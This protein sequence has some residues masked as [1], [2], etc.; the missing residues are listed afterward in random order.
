MKAIWFYLSFVI[1]IGALLGA[2]LGG[3]YSFVTVL[4]AFVI[5][6]VIDLL[7]QQETKALSSDEI[8]RLNL[9][10]SFRTVPFL[11]GVFMLGTFFILAW[12][13]SMKET[14][15]VSFIGITVSCGIATGGVSIAVAH[16]LIHK[17]TSGE[18]ALGKALLL[19]IAYMH[20]YIDHNA[21]HH[22]LVATREDASS[23]RMGES[24][25]RFFP[26]TLIGSYLSAW[27]IEKKRLRKVKSGALFFQNR[28]IQFL[29]FTIGFALLL[30]IL[31]GPK[32]VLFYG[33]Q[34]VLGFT[35]LEV[36]NY[37][38]HYG[39]ERKLEA[40]GRYE[41]V[42]AC[43]SWEANGRVSN[44]VFFKFQR[45]A[46]H[47]IHPSRCYHVLQPLPESPKL[48][49]G[50]PGMALLAFVSP[51]WHWIMDKRVASLQKSTI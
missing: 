47:H 11:F 30:F 37:V 17:S 4:I 22:T 23:A 7:D 38:E 25:F 15:L 31:F 46:D 28:M 40:N 9:K 10:K 48:P 13:A 26:R 44:Y 5:I 42:Q 2:F 19:L 49:T 29:A 3:M 12:R 33:V 34:A 8:S 18:R 14:N 51:V 43:H 1:P 35:I 41:R 21:G 50:Y 27:R 45:H 32:G 16:E 39:L 36:I 6:P 20:Y 24:F